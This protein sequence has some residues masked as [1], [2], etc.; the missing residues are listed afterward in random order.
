L[1]YSRAIYYDNRNIILIFN[2]LILQKFELINIFIGDDKLK[3]LLLCQYILSYLINLFFNTLLY[4]DDIIS[5][6]YEND[7]DLDIFISLM[8]SILSNIITSIIRYFLE[9]TKSSEV[10]IEEILLLKKKTIYIKRLVQ[11]IKILKIKSCIFF[12]SEIIIII[13]AFYYIII[14]SIIY[15]KSKLSAFI[16]YLYSLLEGLIISIAIAIIV[17]ITRK[18]SLCYKIR[19]LYNT[20]KFIND[21]F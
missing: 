2:S 12:L 3:I 18:M 6:K 13:F 10:L 1:P 8:L 14:F 21:K 7:G 5:N 15:S 16:N 4:T 20:S 17:T 11:F 19:S 9:C